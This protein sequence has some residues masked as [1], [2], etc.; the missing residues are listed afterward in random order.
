MLHLT[1]QLLHRNYTCTDCK[2]WE[3]RK[4]EKKEEIFKCF[5]KKSVSVNCSQ[6]SYTTDGRSLNKLG[7][8]IIFTVIVR[9]VILS[10]FEYSLSAIAPLLLGPSFFTTPWQKSLDRLDVEKYVTDWCTAA[11]QVSSSVTCS[12]V[13]RKLWLGFIFPFDFLFGLLYGLLSI[14]QCQRY[15][16]TFVGTTTNP[17]DEFFFFFF[18]SIVSIQLR[19]T[20]MWVHIILYITA[21]L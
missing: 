9:R 5:Y 21:A 3:E 17:M 14:R 16:P 11:T 15:K 2:L 13:I 8:Y 1:M 4:K 10:T 7:N 6:M 12:S 19:N 20:C 18:H